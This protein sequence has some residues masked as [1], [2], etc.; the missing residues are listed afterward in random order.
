MCLF[1]KDND[2]DDDKSLEKAACGYNCIL[3][4]Y[5]NGNYV[6]NGKPICAD[7]PDKM[8]LF[9]KDSDGDD[10]KS[11]EKAACGYNCRLE[12]NKAVCD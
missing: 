7:T 12:N 4:R 5:S 11:L 3:P 1:A 2:A 8:C 10:D 9:A 6:I